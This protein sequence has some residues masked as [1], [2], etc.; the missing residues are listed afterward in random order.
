MISPTLGIGK[1]PPR[2]SSRE[3]GVANFLV[4]KR[5][6]GRAGARGV[7]GVIWGRAETPA[8]IASEA[9]RNEVLMIKN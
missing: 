6:K 8:E 9:D 4:L 7:E 5:L 3:R 1:F 2:M